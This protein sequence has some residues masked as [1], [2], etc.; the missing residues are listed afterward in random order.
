MSPLT[1][2]ARRLSKWYRG[3][4]VYPSLEDSFEKMER[5]TMEQARKRWEN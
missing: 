2:P 5:E 3:S 4:R 1:L